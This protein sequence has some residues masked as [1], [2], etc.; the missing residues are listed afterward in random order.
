MLPSW[1]TFDEYKLY[2]NGHVRDLNRVMLYDNDDSAY[3]VMIAS[4]IPT[5]K[6]KTLR[7]L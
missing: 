5:Q 3:H 2:Q 6:E 7:S 4:V 1:T